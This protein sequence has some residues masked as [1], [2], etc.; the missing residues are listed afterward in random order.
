MNEYILD[1]LSQITKEEQEILHNK[2]GVDKKIYTSK[3]DF[4]IDSSKM[5][6]RGK[7][8]DIR[9]H[10]RFT[11]FPLH[12]HNYIEIIYVYKGTSRHYINNIHEVVLQQG[13]MLF[14]NQFTAHSIA[15]ASA[16]DIVVNIMVLP[17]FFDDAF[18]IVAKESVVGRFL[19]STLCSNTEEGKYLHFQ[20][21]NVVQVHNLVDNI[22]LSFLENRENVEKINR[23]TMA[24]LLL[25]LLGCT[26]IIS[27]DNKENQQHI[28]LL[29][30]LK[31][32][33]NNYKTARLLE[34]SKQLSIPD[35]K[36]CKLIKSST[37]KTFATHLL[38]KRLEKSLQLLTTTTLSIADIITAVGYDNTS[39]FY[40]VFKGKYGATPSEYR[41]QNR[42]VF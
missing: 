26:Q 32:I 25:E 21:A 35:Y 1:K 10:T 24:V 34:V 5:L 11:S 40:R 27:Q 20:S 39:Y 37:G 13:E 4:T 29:E 33:E 30:T 3:K 31:Y 28:I 42:T 22:I 7:L 19:S 36:L 38:D 14:L 16:D 18:D 15:P 8:I 23:L 9:T 41:L 12:K 2:K 6:Q 17:Q